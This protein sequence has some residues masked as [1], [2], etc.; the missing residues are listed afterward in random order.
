LLKTG[1]EWRRTGTALYYA[2]HYDQLTGE[3]GQWLLQFPKLLQVASIGVFY[4]ELLIVLLL[5]FPFGNL[6]VRTRIRFVAVGILVSFHLGIA[7]TM[8]L[9]LIPYTNLAALWLFV[10]SEFWEKLRR[11]AFTS[12]SQP[13]GKKAIA[14]ISNLAGVFLILYI[15]FWNVGTVIPSVDEKLPHKL[16]TLLRL[17]QNW[18]FYAPR[19]F[20]VDGWWIFPGKTKDGLPANAWTLEKAE[21]KN[22]KPAKVSNNFL[23]DSWW[24]RFNTHWMAH[25]ILSLDPQNAAHR[26]YMLDYLCRRWNKKWTGQ[27]ALDEISYVYVEEATQLKEEEITSMPRVLVSKKCPIENPDPTLD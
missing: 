22:L 4:L 23:T 26:E 5:F 11:T 1:D 12:S 21:V 2:F 7:S 15:F 17:D 16:G 10:P 6:K 24:S 20:I 27:S 3:L 13:V 19:P 25:S 8:T 14:A 9:F 18:G